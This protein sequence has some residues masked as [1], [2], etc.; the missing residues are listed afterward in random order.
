[1]KMSEDGK[2][3][4]LLNEDDAVVIATEESEAA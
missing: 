4:I 3:Y 1:L 2:E